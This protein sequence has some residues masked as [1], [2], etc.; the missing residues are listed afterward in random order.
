VR[1]Q[2]AG[3][4]SRILLW[5]SHGCPPRNNCTSKQRCHVRT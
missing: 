5:L 3:S 4:V 1:S 2:I